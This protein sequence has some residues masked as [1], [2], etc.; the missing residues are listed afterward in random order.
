MRITRTMTNGDTGKEEFISV[1]VAECEGGFTYQVF[2][3]AP[4]AIFPSIDAAADAYVAEALR[5]HERQ[6]ARQQGRVVQPSCHYCGREAS[7][8]SNV[9]GVYQCEECS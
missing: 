6:M 4:T 1:P 9:V 8:R 3:S 7:A 5:R 2:A